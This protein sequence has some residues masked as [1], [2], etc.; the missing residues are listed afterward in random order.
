MKNNK[1]FVG[2]FLAVL[3]LCAVSTKAEARTHFSLNIG[4]F[5]APQPVCERYVVEHYQP[6][7][8]EPV[9]AYPE[10]VVYVA[11]RPVYRE[12]YVERPVYRSGASMTMW[13][14]YR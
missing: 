10:R 7:Y 12:V 2:F 8:A 4:G 5:F 13:R 11:P 1:V 3:C 9:Y 6:Y 14:S